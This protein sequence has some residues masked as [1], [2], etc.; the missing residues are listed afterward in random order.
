MLSALG[1]LWNEYRHPSPFINVR[2]L[3]ANPSLLGVYGH[4]VLFS[5]V[6]YCGIYGLPQW[7]EVSRGFT[8][9]E[10]GLLI[11]P[12]AMMGGVVTPAVSWLIRRRGVR[13][14]LVLSGSLLFIGCA[15]IYLFGEGV[16][17]WFIVLVCAVLGLPNAMTNLGLQTRMYWAVSDGLG[18]AAG[19][20]QTAR[21]VGGIFST[22]VLGIVFAAGVDTGALH[23][24]VSVMLVL[25]AVIV[26]L[27]SLRSK[28]DERM[29]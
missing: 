1:F 24:M 11:F 28:A 4:F 8:P 19:L 26:V 2:M 18:V 5:V 17:T 7:L 22:S 16:P 23:A 14:T 20:Y 6:F 3:K 27:S 29:Q 9:A 25:A 21:Y 10:V 12:L 13:F 15:A